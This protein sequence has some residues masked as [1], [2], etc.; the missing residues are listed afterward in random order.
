MS[1]I[2]C[3][4]W[5]QGRTGAVDDNGIVALSRVFVVET[6]SNHDSPA[7][8]IAGLRY[9]DPDPEVPLGSVPI[10]VYDPHPDYRAA[11]LRNCQ[12]AATESPRLWRI[13]V[14]YSS[15]PLRAQQQS[16][17]SAPLNPPGSS[18]ALPSNDPATGNTNSKPATDRLPTWTYSVKTVEEPGE[19][20]LDA[21]DDEIKPYVNAVGDPIEGLTVQRYNLSATVEYYSFDMTDEEIANRVGVVNHAP[22]G[23]FPT[24]GIIVRDIRRSDQFDYI[25][26]DGDGPVFGLVWKVS[27]ELEC[28]NKEYFWLT[29]VL[30]TGRRGRLSAGGPIITFVDRNGERLADPIPL[31]EDGIALRNPAAASATVIS[32]GEFNYLVFNDK[33][34]FD[35]EDLL[36]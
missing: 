20:Y 10:R 34:Y 21:V 12:C 32:P 24:G 23:G 28:V 25:G 27:I 29:K 9:P 11:V 16:S 4:E 8:A 2:K 6:N 3:S 18:P 22:W 14:N 5:L 17:G 26:D 19:R 15:A 33:P 7:I 31:D 30:N 13:T 36:I 35:F 1:V